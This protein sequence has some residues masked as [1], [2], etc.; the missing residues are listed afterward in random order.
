MRCTGLLCVLGLAQACAAPPPAE[1][2]PAPESRPARPAPARLAPAPVGAAPET[3][4][5]DPAGIRVRTRIART[6]ECGGSVVDDYLRL[7]APAPN[8]LVARWLNQNMGEPFRARVAVRRGVVRLEVE[9]ID[10]PFSSLICGMQAYHLRTEISGLPAGTY[11][12]VG[13]EQPVEHV[14]GRVIHT[15]R[16]RARIA[17]AGLP[18]DPQKTWPRRVARRR[19][20]P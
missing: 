9:A 18:A 12:V 6:E 17:V 13:P 10:D 7:A 1:P 20:G 4:P 14:L 11:R 3:P 5:L 15:P 19:L 16:S 8:R 2:R